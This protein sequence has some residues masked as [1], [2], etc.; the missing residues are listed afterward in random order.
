M[1]GVGRLPVFVTHLF[2]ETLHRMHRELSTS[3][4]NEDQLY[5]LAPHHLRS[6][7]LSLLL[8]LLHHIML[9]QGYHQI[10]H[11]EEIE[12]YYLS[13]AVKFR[14]VHFSLGGA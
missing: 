10:Q 13:A 5:S 11:S 3:R 4:G 12:A 7:P 8:L 2:P 9:A 1:C 14:S 6:I